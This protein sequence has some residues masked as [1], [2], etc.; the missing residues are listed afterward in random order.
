MLHHKTRAKISRI[1]LEYLGTPY[2]DGGQIKGL[3]CDCA[4]LIICIAREALGIKIPREFGLKA[5]LDEFF[6]PSENA[7]TGDIILFK[8]KETPDEFHAAMMLENKILHSRQPHGVIL[9]SYSR[10]F[11]RLAHSFYSFKV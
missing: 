10:H 6:V 7:K 5:S 8:R 11:Q 3:G 2:F 9:N 1:A 4:G